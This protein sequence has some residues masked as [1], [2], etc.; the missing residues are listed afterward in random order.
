MYVFVCRA[1]NGQ[2]DLTKRFNT[3]LFDVV[4]GKPSVPPGA[5]P[6]YSVVDS[7]KAYYVLP[8]HPDK[9]RPIEFDWPAMISSLKSG[10]IYRKKVNFFGGFAKLEAGDIECDLEA[11]NP[12]EIMMRNGKFSAEDLDDAMI[13]CAHNGM[14]CFVT[15]ILKQINGSSCFPSA[16]SPG[17]LTYADYYASK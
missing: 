17:C 11:L 10:L 7:P 12:G 4:L 3:W 14:P 15:S 8:L 1:M 6:K 13:T 5:M 16:D 2:V 9:S